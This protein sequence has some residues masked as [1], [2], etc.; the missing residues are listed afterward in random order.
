MTL[1]P[2]PDPLEPIVETLPAGTVLHRI[3]EPLLPA[4]SPNDGTIGN[5]GVGKPTRFAFFGDPAVPV[6]YA[7]STPQA[8]VHE[9]VLHDAEPGMFL[10]RA[11]W[12]SK[13]LSVLHTTVGIPIAMFHGEGLRRFGLFASDLT[14]TDLTAYP[15]TV[16]WAEAAWRAGLAGVSYMCRHHN[17]SRAVCLFTDRLD[18]EALTAA[19]SHPDTK[20]FTLPAD[21]AWLADIALH[22]R[23]TTRP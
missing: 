19:P 13:V 2:P 10:P 18:D 5:P 9:S 12:A 15:R 16:A 6:L 21:A 7:A 3:H 20:V 22:M 4:G 14:D 17:S 8:A 11:H 1:P 23:V